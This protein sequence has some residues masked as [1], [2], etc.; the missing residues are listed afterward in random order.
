MTRRTDWL[1]LVLHVDERSEYAE[2]HSHDRPVDW[3][4]R[5]TSLVSMGLAGFLV[6]AAAVGIAESRPAVEEVTA[7]LR[8]RVTTAQTAVGIA[9]RDYR[10]AREQLKFTQ[11]AVRPDIGGELASSLDRQALAAGFVGLRGP[12]LVLTMDNSEKPTFSGTTDLGEVIDRDVQHAVNALWKAGAEGVSING[13][14]LTGRT[15]IRNAGAT[16][17]VDYRPV[18]APYDIAAVGDAARLLQ[19]FKVTAEWSELRTLRDRYRI[20]WSIELRKLIEM[21]AGA[22]TLPNQAVAGGES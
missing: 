15:S 10:M 11:D 14:R 21:P 18:S 9:E 7:A 2:A 12:G 4:G 3:L 6:V 1:Q 22:S 13:V 5:S 20:R 19:Q 8:S 16:V 17:L